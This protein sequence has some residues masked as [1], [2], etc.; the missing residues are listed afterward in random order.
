MKEK[1]ITFPQDHQLPN[2]EEI[3][4]KVYC[5]YNNSWNHG[6]N[7]CWSM[8]N[9]IQDNINKGILKF[10]EKK[11]AMV[12]VEYPFPQVASVNIA[13]TNLRA[14]LNENKDGRFSPNVK[15]RKVWI[16]KQY[17]VYKDELAVEGKVSTAKEK[18]NN[19]RYPYHYK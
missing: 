10:L 3:K 12:I 14:V 4:G 15:I 6:T 19:G 2:K 5:K 11:G 17:L 1:F 9:I 7:F 8:R 16:P 13:S 18:E